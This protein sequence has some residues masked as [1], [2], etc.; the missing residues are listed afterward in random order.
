M[1]PVVSVPT[2]NILRFQWSDTLTNSLDSS[3][4]P[5]PPRGVTEHRSSSLPVPAVLTQGQCKSW[6][7]GGSMFPLEFHLGS[8]AP[9][10]GCRVREAFLSV[11][12]RVSAPFLCTLLCQLL[13]DYHI[14]PL[15]PHH[16]LCAHSAD[17]APGPQRSLQ[18]S[19]ILWRKAWPGAPGPV[20]CG[21]SCRL[22]L[23]L[24]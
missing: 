6:H 8:C 2:Q 3:A 11:A 20:S 14:M 4:Y 19:F 13:P 22:L 24:L 5:L 9:Y 15:V 7:W 10:A 18:L 23:A 16:A 17:G 1:I 12:G 21:M